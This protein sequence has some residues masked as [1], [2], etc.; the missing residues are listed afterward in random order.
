MVIAEIDVCEVERDGAL[1]VGCCVEEENTSDDEI[2]VQS[3]LVGLGEEYR[4][5]GKCF[6]SI[7]HFASVPE[8]H[9]LEVQPYEYSNKVIIKECRPVKFS[10]RSSERQRSLTG[11][12][13]FSYLS[14]HRLVLSD[15]RLPT[16]G[17]LQLQVP[18]GR[19]QVLGF[20]HNFQNML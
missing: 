7:F 18:L 1:R 10:S 2:P 11:V 17:A 20:L 16:Q 5:L 3:C 15:I 13:A 6:H 8:S 9:H 4:D 19:E 14:N 12:R